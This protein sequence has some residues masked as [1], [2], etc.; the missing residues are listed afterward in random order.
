MQL[1]YESFTIIS[2]NSLLLYEYKYY[3]QVYLDNCAYKVAN[4]QLIDYLE[5]NLFDLIKIS[6]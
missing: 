4:T 6:F 1:V 5:E 2:I 3:L